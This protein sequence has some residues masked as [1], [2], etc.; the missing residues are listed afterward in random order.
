MFEWL[1]G[2]ALFLLSWFITFRVYRHAQTHQWMDHPNARS[3]HTV[4]TP[5]GG[6][7]AFVIVFSAVLV[8]QELYALAVAGLAV[9]MIGWLDDHKPMSPYLR[10]MVH[11]FAA[12]LVVFTSDPMVDLPW[13][14]ALVGHPVVYGT[15]F[16]LALVWMIN[17]TNFM[18]GIDG[19]AATQTVTTALSTGLILFWVYG[20]A[21][22]AGLYLALA[23]TVFGFLVW[24]WPPAK[25]FMGDV[26]SG[27]LG[28]IVGGLFF[29]SAGFNSN[30]LWIGLILYAVFI[31]DATVTLFKRLAARQSVLEPHNNH[32][33][34]MAAR[35]LGSHRKV[36]L[37]VM[38]INLVFLLPIAYWVAI[39]LIEAW[40][41][42]ML[43]YLPLTLIAFKM[44][45]L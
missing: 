23:M 28:M 22:Q 9:A 43:V 1:V 20:E 34:Q 13:L 6:G 33:Y 40:F 15:L 27:F 44:K 29:Y 30:V 25:I 18:D 39:E 19:L 2:L 42:L 10:L 7:L 32:S 11:L 16:V 36:T 5:K 37:A 38:A 14:A 3:S 12:T 24:N 4:P 26:G 21:G 41:G 17:L 8:W 45:Q 31:V 35:Y